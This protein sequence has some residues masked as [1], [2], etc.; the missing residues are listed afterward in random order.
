MLRGSSVRKGGFDSLI[1]QNN[2]TEEEKRKE[3]KGKQKKTTT[4]I[5]SSHD[6]I[7]LDRSQLLVLR[8]CD[9]SHR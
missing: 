1:L 5:S 3:E 2:K 4:S 6:S 9:P 8:S 7:V